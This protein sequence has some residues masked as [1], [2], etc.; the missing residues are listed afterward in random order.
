MSKPVRRSPRMLLLN[1][2]HNLRS[3]PKF[4]TSITEKV[5]TRLKDSLGI[6][7]NRNVESFTQSKVI[8]GVKSTNVVK[9][10]QICLQGSTLSDDSDSESGSEPLKPSPG[11]R[12][13]I[14]RITDELLSDQEEGKDSDSDLKTEQILHKGISHEEMT[15][16]YDDNVEQ[17]EKDEL[18][19]DNTVTENVKG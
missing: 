4:K 13:S 17:T 15:P 1:K 18:K 11:R 7:K 12:G 9:E 10:D 6:S 14:R 2:K 5:K 19:G 3:S 16:A 8:P